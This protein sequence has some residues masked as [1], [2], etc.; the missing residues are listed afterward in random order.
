[1][2]EYWDGRTKAFKSIP[3]APYYVLSSD[4]FMSHKDGT[5]AEGK[6]NVCVVP[7]DDHETASRVA[8]YARSRN[9]QKRVR[10]VT[11]PPRAKSSVLYSLLDRWIETSKQ[12]LAG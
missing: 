9:D 5:P 8:A 6:T 10:I 4:P 2:A 3:N 12:G 7:C 1:M 11:S